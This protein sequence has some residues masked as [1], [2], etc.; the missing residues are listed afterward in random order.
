MENK[1]QLG[2]GD[3]VSD[4][5]TPIVGLAAVAAWFQRQPGSAM[6]V[7]W[8]K[9]HWDTLPGFRQQGGKIFFHPRTFNH[10][11]HFVTASRPTP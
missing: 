10:G 11:L 7:S 6:S 3:A 2:G 4:L 8:L 9:K 5:D 1:S